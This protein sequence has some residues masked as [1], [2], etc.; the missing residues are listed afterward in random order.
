MYN[1]DEESK[2][3]RAKKSS[4]SHNMLRY[5]GRFSIEPSDENAASMATQLQELRS[6]HEI[7]H[8][9]TFDFCSLS[10]QS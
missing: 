1:D 9:L 2:S 4:T 6:L 10:L 3:E 5:V 7:K 8:Q